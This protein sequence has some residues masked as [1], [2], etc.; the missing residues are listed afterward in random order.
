[1]R[2]LLDVIAHNW[3]LKLVALVVALILWSLVRADEPFQ[4]TEWAPVEVQVTDPDWQLARPPQP[5]SVEVTF[6]GPF[7]DL[8]RVGAARPR[9][10]VPVENVKDTTELRVLSGNLV[11]LQ[12]DLGRTRVEALHPNTVTLHYEPLET[13]AVPVRATTRGELPAGFALEM[14]LRSSPSVVQVRGPAARVRRIN[15]LDLDPID[16]SDIRGVTTVPT[17][18]DTA[19][20]HGL[21]VSP[22]D[23]SVTVHAVPADT[24]GGNGP[25][26]SPSPGLRARPGPA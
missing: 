15:S 7:R 16:L 4:R 24:T 25:A 9:V 26:G 17:T 6:S 3:A 14:P 20:I 1:M 23:I 5:D 2:R 19:R 12:D 10:V 18:V 21:V 22:V 8:W 13:R 11:R